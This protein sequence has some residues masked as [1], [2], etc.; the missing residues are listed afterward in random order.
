MADGGSKMDDSVR[1]F[2]NATTEIDRLKQSVAGLGAANQLLAELTDALNST[3]KVSGDAAV[4]LEAA[5]KGTESATAELARFD[6]DRILSEMISLRERVVA[7]AD[8]T[9]DVITAATNHI[10]ASIEQSRSEVAA[11]TNRLDA[12]IAQSRSEVAEVRK[13]AL[14]GFVILMVWVGALALLV[15]V[16]N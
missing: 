13:L 10:D 2:R 4:A 14:T 8:R 15:L 7:E 12:S 1:A 5:A 9:R 11:A 3:C 6:P 16:V